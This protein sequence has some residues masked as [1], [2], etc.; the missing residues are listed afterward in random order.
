MKSK[1]NIPVGVALFVALALLAL[2]AVVTLPQLSPSLV[3]GQAETPLQPPTNLTAQNTDQR[4]IL[5][6]WTAP[7]SGPEVAGYRV[8]RSEDG[9]TGWAMVGTV[10]VTELTHS[11]THTAT[12]NELE[13]G[14]TYYYRVSATAISPN[15][16]SR[17][18]NVANATTGEVERPDAPTALVLTAQGPSRIDLAWTAP[19]EPVGG[20]IT[21]YKIEYSDAST[22][23]VLVANTGNIESMY[24]DDGSIAP[25]EEGDRR[26]YRVSAINSAGAGMASASALSFATP[27][28]ARVA[29]SAPTG[30]T[31]MTMGPMEVKLSWTAPTDTSGDEITG[32]QIEYSDLNN[33]QFP[34]FMDLV[35]T[36]GNDET[37]YTDDGSDAALA[38]ETTRQYRVLAINA[39]VTSSASNLAIATT[40]KATA[41]GKPKAPMP[42]PTATEPQTITVNWTAPT[43]TGGTEITGYRIERSENGS[44]WPAEPLVPNTDNANLIYPDR[45]VPKAN[46]RWYYRV[47]AINIVGRGEPSDAANAVTSTAIRPGV[48]IDLTAW[49]EGP[50]RIV[51]QWKAP[52]MTGGEIT[53]YKIQYSNADNTGNASNNLWMDLVS[54]TMSDATTYTDHGSVA[55]LGAGT[56]RYYR[57]YAIN[58]ADTSATASNPYSA[59]TG[60]TAL[61]PPTG[62]IAEKT[63]QRAITLD[64]TAPTSGAPGAGYRV[65]RSEDGRTGWAMVGTGVT[66]LTHSDTHTATTNELEFGKTYYYRVST[67][68]TSPGNRRS[69]PS[70]VANATTGEVERPAAPTIGTATPEGPSRIL[71][72]WTF[73][74][75]TSDGGGEITGYK[76]EYSDASTWEVLVANTGN[77]K[78]MYT[79]DGSIAPLEKDDRRNYRVSA[80][81]SA[82]AG[83][84]SGSVLGGPTP[85]CSTGSDQCA[86]G[87]DG[88]GD[89]AD[90][91]EA[92]MDYAH[93]YHRR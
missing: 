67:T 9:R 1:I 32:Y 48:P 78:L 3:F 15:R 25:L 14:K 69:R 42:V 17:P 41:P 86:D 7:T 75:D 74:A 39:G 29:P 10:G 23:R 34:V 55:E 6:Y 38:A 61:Q 81:N 40:A 19:P 58:S 84:A 28:A 36:T 30:L 57:V 62:L 63:D 27:S 88:H 65:E 24:T 79:D 68:A 89:G 64:W 60:T 76:I 5:L 82:G 33:G 20:E 54:N 35:E 12:A 70:N 66:E 73:P 92:V 80:I 45:T 52:A 26:R 43:N 4:V 8:E 83:M 22:W 72:T 51:L 87:P 93:G 18:S 13:F 56:I 53:G 31:A 46:T 47:S 77:T 59:I 44:T 85:L 21:G 37:T 11:D 16:R 90:G 71:L 91:S 49:E 2:S 50:T